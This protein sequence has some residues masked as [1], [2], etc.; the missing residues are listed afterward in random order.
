MQFSIITPSFRNSAWLKLCI[1][2]VAD[3]Q[4]V[5]VE[6]VVQDAG[7][8]DGT[9][10]WLSKDP[11]V[12]VFVERDTGMYDAINRGL[13]RA[14]GEIVAY[15]NCD[16]QYLPG[17]LKKAYNFFDAHPDTDVLFGDAIVVNREGG[18]ICHRK[19][20]MPL[21][22]QMW[23]RFP[24][25]TCATFLRREV[26]ERHRLYFDTSWRII[27]D[28]FWIKQMVKRKIPMALIHEFTSV[29]AD[30][31]NNLSFQP[32]AE[33]ER[34]RMLLMRPGLV[35]ILQP[36]IIFHHRLRMLLNG[37]YSQRPFEYSIYTSRSPE[38]RTV[39]HVDAPTGLWRDR[40]DSIF[41]RGR[42]FQT[43]L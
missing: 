37:S 7:S 27:G 11:R 35:E 29:F 5:A 9:L 25:L 12:S 18:Y 23:Y 42:W 36:A 2:S 16:E 6:H 33:N 13:R 41:L 28:F 31:G 1:A 4:G 32:N 19:A 15:L 40:T 17:A 22:S 21:K 38:Q 20:L 34:S 8:D 24:V 39:F 10:E 26:L 14:K 30:T 3:Q 43:Q